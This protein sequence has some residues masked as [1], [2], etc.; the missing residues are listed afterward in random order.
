MRKTCIKNLRLKELKAVLLDN[1]FKAFNATQVFEWLYRKNVEDFQDMTNISKSLR[2]FLYDNYFISKLHIQDR[3]ISEDETQKFL[4][5]LQDGHCI[6]TVMI[7]EPKRKTLCLSTQ[8][9]CKRKCSFCVSGRSGFV[10]DLS[11]AEIVNQVMQVNN[12]I[13][14]MKISNIVFMGVGEPLDNFDNLFTAID[15]IRE[16]KGIYIGKRKISISSCGLI[17]EIER[18]IK[19]NKDTRL[20]ISLHSADDTIRSKIMPVN[21]VYPL[22]DLMKVLKKF[23]K[24]MGFPVFFEYILVKDLNSSLEDAKKLAKLLKGT[25]GKVNLIPH[26]DSPYSDWQ[27][28]SDD[29]INLFRNELEKHKVF[30]TLRKSRGQDISAACGQLRAKHKEVEK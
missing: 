13:A 30:Y 2:Q 4:F 26:N 28:P 29:A 9:G 15:V 14:P 16:E 11:A 3:Q 10:R 8:V 27:A 12:A 18:M 6:E 1:G 25:R 21:R 5:K 22:A 24:H 19:E 23:E 17:P 7:P 20:S